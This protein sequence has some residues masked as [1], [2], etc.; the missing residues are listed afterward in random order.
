MWSFFTV[1]LILV[2]SFIPILIWWYVFSYI[3]D[4]K[5]NKSR[6]FYGILAGWFSVVPILYLDDII[7]YSGTN[8]LNMFSYIY[9][10]DTIYSAFL[11]FLSI[12]LFS[13]LLFFIS[14]LFSLIFSFNFSKIKSLFLLLLKSFFIFLLFIFFISIFSYLLSLFFDKFP[15]LDLSIEEWSWWTFSGIAFNSLKLVIFYYFIVWI[16]EELAKHFNFLSTSE[17]KIDSIKSWV[18]FSIFVALGF[19]FIENI[20]YFKVIY[21][22]YSLSWQLVSTYFFRSI[23]SVFVHVLCSSVLAYAFTKAYLSYKKSFNNFFFIKTFLIWVSYSILLHS[24]FDVSL[25]LWF[26]FIV[27][28]YFI[29]AYLYITS[30]FYKEKD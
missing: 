1:I 10:I 28:L 14:F 22:T 2:I 3:D 13:F 15:G 21:E 29:W 6:F 17:L 18:L 12:W 26:T 19:S 8:I 20:L 25:S 9:S 16:I 24:I 30:I 4:S 23:F 11:F 5:L 27:F 7:D